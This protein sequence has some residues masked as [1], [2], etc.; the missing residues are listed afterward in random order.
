[1][2]EYTHVLLA[3][4]LTE[5]SHQVAEKAAAIAKQHGAKLSVMHIVE[6]MPAYVDT[7]A[8]AGVTDIE[9]GLIEEAKSN[10]AELS[11]TLNVA[12]ADQHIEV[13]PP[14]YLIVKRAE[15]LGADLIV[16]GSHGRHGM[17][18]LLGSTANAVVNSA[19]VDVLVVRY[20]D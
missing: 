17:S 5:A 19:H 9:Q 4:D 14:K 20:S 6:P 2:S 13:G 12:P 18:W 15:E 3:S 7:G 1:M 11:L 10:C 8:Y 16:V